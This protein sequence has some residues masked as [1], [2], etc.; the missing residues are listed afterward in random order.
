MPIYKCRVKKGT[1]EVSEQN[2]EAGS[3]KD[4]VEKLSRMG[5]LPLKVE[6]I[7][8]DERAQAAS[9]QPARVPRGGA[10]RG[11]ARSRDI[12]IFTR[13]LASLFK[14]GV[15]ILT[16]LNIII[17]QSENASLK[18]MLLD[19]HDEVK[20]GSTLSAAL[21]KYP[22]AFPPLYIAMVRTGENSGALPAVLFSIADHR[23]KEETMISHLRMAMAYPLLMAVVGAGTIVFMFAFVI[24]RLTKIY[25]TMGQILPLPTRILLA[26]SDF[27]AKGWPVLVLALAAGILIFRR[28]TRTEKGKEAWSRFVLK[29][30]VWGKFVVK[31]ELVRFCRTFGLLMKS[32]VPILSAINIAIPVLENDVVKNQISQSYKELEH[33]GTFGKSLKNSKAIPLFMSNLVSVGEESGRLQDALEEVASSYERDT[34]EAVRMMSNLLEPLMILFMG[35]IVGFMVIAMLLPIFDI[36]TAMH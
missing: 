17:E 2:I 30:P 36:N 35:L 20:E 31:A 22:Q 19:I 16:A 33:G 28:Q 23:I 6:E 29:L 8:Q 12:T 18:A 13:Q 24:P 27:F 9:V 26:V 14:S 11:K 4:V 3:E 15:P 34:E 25:V 5:L 7:A 10:T 1:E 21:E 32:G